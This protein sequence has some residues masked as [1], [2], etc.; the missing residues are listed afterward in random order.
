ME[1]IRPAGAKAQGQ[2]RLGQVDASPAVGRTAQT[3]KKRGRAMYRE[4][5]A[6]EAK[7]AVVRKVA[8]NSRSWW[9]NSGMLLNVV[10]DLKRANVLGMPRLS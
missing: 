8:A 2:E 10:L 4:L 1:S 9:R 6:M 3:V 7:P 5:P